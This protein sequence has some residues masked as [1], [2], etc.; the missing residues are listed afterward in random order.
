MLLSPILAGIGRGQVCSS[1]PRF[2]VFAICREC[3]SNL[4]SA[5][6]CFDQALQR[7]LEIARQAL[8]ESART[9]LPA[10]LVF[11][12]GSLREVVTELLEKSAAKSG[13]LPPRTKKARAKERHLL[14]YLQRVCA[15]ND[16]LSEFGPGSWGAID[17]E[18]MQ[19]L[20][21]GFIKP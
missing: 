9:V 20:V 17:R 3:A 7:E 16:T 4:A 18:T 15:K 19:S 2:G 10:Y 14:L 12:A 1:D 8:L 11:A 5:E 13:P 6:M 21:K